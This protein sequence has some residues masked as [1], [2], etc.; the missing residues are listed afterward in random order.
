[1]CSI[2]VK[3][4]ILAETV[5]FW[6]RHNPG[7]P[8]HSPNSFLAMSAYSMCLRIFEKLKTGLEWGCLSALACLLWTSGFG[9]RVTSSL[10]THVSSVNTEGCQSWEMNR[11]AYMTAY[12]YV[13]EFMAWVF[14]ILSILFLFCSFFCLFKDPLGIF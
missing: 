5:S 2:H 7:R 6:T 13:T 14:S 9:V 11:D 3:C 10:G 1:M 12:V 8:T 4:Y